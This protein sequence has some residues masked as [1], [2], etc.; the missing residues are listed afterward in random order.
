M[1]NAKKNKH[2]I[3]LSYYINDPESFGVVKFG[4]KWTNYYY[5]TKGK[6]PKINYAVKATAR[7]E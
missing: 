2:V 6:I 3:V 1:R 4:E 5:G 7:R